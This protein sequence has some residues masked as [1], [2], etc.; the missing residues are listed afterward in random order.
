MQK[1]LF[2]QCD[3][4]FAND[5]PEQDGEDLPLSE[6]FHWKSLPDSP[7]LAPLTGSPPPV[8]NTRP[9][10]SPTEP[11][12]SLPRPDASEELPEEEENRRLTVA[13]KVEPNPAVENGAAA[14]QSTAQTRKATAVTVSQCARDG[15]PYLIHLLCKHLIIV[16]S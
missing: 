15:L 10:E 12:S 8:Q 4:R 13:V 3:N 11:Q 5:G 16:N 1:S 6:G 14:D 7:S 9:S 2:I